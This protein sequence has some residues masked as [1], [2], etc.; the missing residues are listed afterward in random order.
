M[1]LVFQFINFSWVFIH[2]RFTFHLAPSLTIKNAKLALEAHRK[3]P[4]HR[5]SFNDGGGGPILLAAKN[6]LPKEEENNEANGRLGGALLKL[7]HS[8]KSAKKGRPR[9]VT[10]YGD[11]MLSNSSKRD[12]SDLVVQYQMQT[13]PKPVLVSNDNDDETPETITQTSTVLS[14][15]L[16]RKFCA[17]SF[18]N[19]RTKISQFF[20]G[21]ARS[22]STRKPNKAESFPQQQ[23]SSDSDYQQE[24]DVVAFRVDKENQQFATNY[25]EDCNYILYS[26]NF[27]ILISGFFCFPKF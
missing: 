23:N 1:F 3:A 26:S 24:E 4:P 19:K 15:K 11:N 13:L 25:T 8:T 18:K 5:R 22:A 20:N 21:I 2:F 10:V 14:P 12:S 7:S 27:C 17:S 16:I 6:S 9:P